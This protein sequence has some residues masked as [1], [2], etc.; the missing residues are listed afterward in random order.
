MALV[1]LYEE[2]EQS[3]KDAVEFEARES[4]FLGEHIEVPEIEY[5]CLM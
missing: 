2:V 3:T 5:S 1:L 4:I